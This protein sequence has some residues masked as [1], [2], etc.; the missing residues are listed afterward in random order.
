MS[1]REAAVRSAMTHG[2]C[3]ADLCRPSRNK[4]PKS[5]IV[6]WMTDRDDHAAH[7]CATAPP[8]CWPRRWERART[9][10]INV[11]RNS[12]GWLRK[13]S[14]RP[15][16]LKAALLRLRVQP[17]T[18]RSR[19]NSRSRPTVARKAGT[20]VAMASVDR[21]GT[22]VLARSEF[23]LAQR[24][25]PYPP[26]ALRGRHFPLGKLCFRLS[27]QPARLS[28]DVPKTSTGPHEQE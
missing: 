7:I 10:T 24:F 8:G 15:P 1:S 23:P 20:K 19:R 18:S 2:H 28:I 22:L 11:P 13:R 14:S 25:V 21:G 6:E 4:S 17:L 26:P 9:A 27:E 5:I 12:R 3:T 16:I